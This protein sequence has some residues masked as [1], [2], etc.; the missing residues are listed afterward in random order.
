MCP[1]S[2]SSSVAEA[3]R[4]L[5]ALRV[6]TESRSE[7][8]AVLQERL[9]EVEYSF[10]EEVARCQQLGEEHDSL[11]EQLIEAQYSNTHLTNEVSVM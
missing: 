10:E 2:S 8:N 3:K 6:E 1:P 7:E 4:R 5:A 11:K 9:A